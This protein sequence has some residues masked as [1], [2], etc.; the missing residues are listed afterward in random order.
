MPVG[1][2]GF[3]SDQLTDRS[4]RFMA[5]ELVREQ[6]FNSLGQELPYETAV[7]VERLERKGKVLNIGATIIVERP[8][9]KGIVIG[10]GGGRLKQIGSHARRELEDYFGMKVFLELWVKLRKDW[11]SSEQAL[12]LLGYGEDL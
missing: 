3:P 11:T 5:A 4:D 1:P 8:G 12:R 6:L 2:P 10:Q 9:Q 7:Q